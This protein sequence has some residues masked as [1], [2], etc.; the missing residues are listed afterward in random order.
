MSEGL[1]PGHRVK[2]RGE[3]RRIQSRGRKVHTRHLILMVHPS[4][5]A[6]DHARLGVT[7]TKKVGN[8]VMRNRI[9]R[10]LREIFRRHRDLF[11]AASDIVVVVKRG[12]RELSY[13]ELLDEIRRARGALRRAA[14]AASKPLD[15]APTPAET[16]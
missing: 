10:L 3:Y 11:P 8:A 4:L 9:R 7:I 2:K 5:R 14:G 12:A 1:P 13:V 15:R 6:A 16:T